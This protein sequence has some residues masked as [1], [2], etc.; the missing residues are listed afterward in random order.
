MWV[1][2]GVGYSVMR[3]LEVKIKACDINIAFLY[4]LSWRCSVAS[5]VTMLHFGVALL[6]LLGNA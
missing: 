2:V 4:T 3:R 1:G 5:S 6:P